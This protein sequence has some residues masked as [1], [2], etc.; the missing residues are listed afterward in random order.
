MLVQ[1]LHTIASAL[2]I[3]VIVLLI[4][5]TIIMVI[6]IGM[7]IA[8]VF[9]ERRYFKLDLPVL[10]DDLGADENPVEVIED[11]DLLQR[12]KQAL[13]EILRHPHAKEA[14]RESMAV[15]LVAAEQ[16]IFDNR[17]KVTDFIAKVAPMLGLMGTLI[18]LGPGIVS[19]GSG[20]TTLLSESLLVAFDTTIL[21]LIVGAIALL[22]STIRKSWYA[23]YMAAF[24][25]AMEC[26]LEKANEM[27]AA[28]QHPSTQVPAQKRASYQ[29][30]AQQSPVPSWMGRRDD[31]V[32]IPRGREQE[33]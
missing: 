15:N 5:L 23:K 21:G 26:V 19:I 7:L 20:D 16:S 4:A 18:P 30:T 28:Q 13:L 24:E 22:V 11:A 29:G 31:D 6:I 17:T 25:A 3:P 8:E 12:Q 14:Q 33:G 2:Q 32:D 10:I 27:A 1:V 9:T